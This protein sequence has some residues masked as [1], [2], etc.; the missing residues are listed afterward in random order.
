[1]NDQD[2]SLQTNI[3]INLGTNTLMGG[4][5][6]S[7]DDDDDDDYRGMGLPESMLQSTVESGFEN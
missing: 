1:M 2:I 7:D 3:P 5:D 4:N 6:D